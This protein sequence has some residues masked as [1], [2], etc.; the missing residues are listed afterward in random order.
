MLSLS[1]YNFFPSTTRLRY[2]FS[3]NMDTS[4]V[5]TTFCFVLFLPMFSF[6]IILQEKLEVQK[7]IKEP[8]TER[9]EQS[10]GKENPE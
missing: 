5:C 1:I 10:F 6:T 4:K 2:D 7:E 8:D 3:I 9:N